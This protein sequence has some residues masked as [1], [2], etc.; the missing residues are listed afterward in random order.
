AKLMKGQIRYLNK[1][2]RQG[3]KGVTN[4]YPRLPRRQG[5]PIE[6]EDLKDEL[7][8]AVEYVEDKEEEIHSNQ[9]EFELKRNQL[10][11]A[12]KLMIV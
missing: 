6:A 2:V 9:K 1:E 7:I 10:L 3:E 4:Y 8:E 11:Q 12:L 5:H